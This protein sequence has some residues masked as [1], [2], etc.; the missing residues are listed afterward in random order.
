MAAALAACRPWALP[1]T[2]ELELILHPELTVVLF[3]RQG[4][5]PEDYE[6]WWRRLLAAQI[7][8]VQ[9][10]SWEGEKV[11]RLCFLNPRTTM[12]H[13]GAILDTMSV[14]CPNGITE[15]FKPSE[16]PSQRNSTA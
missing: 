11:A 10:T 1:K 4:W 16:K 3:R 8:F 14:S 13:V 9:P 6:T 15:H 12:D 2:P 7:A 5:G